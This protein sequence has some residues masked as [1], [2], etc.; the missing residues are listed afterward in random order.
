MI[1]GDSDSK[2]EKQRHKLVHLINAKSF[3]KVPLLL[4]TVPVAAAAAIAALLAPGQ[5][6]KKVESRLPLAKRT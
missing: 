2:A 5:L 4:C 6:L 1:D 3:A